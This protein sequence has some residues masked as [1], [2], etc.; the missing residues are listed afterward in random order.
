[1]CADNESCLPYATQK[2]L[3]R[4]LNLKHVGIDV[5]YPGENIRPGT[6]V[7]YSEKSLFFTLG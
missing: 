6:C 4:F 7:V 1:M 3:V 2:A 5:R